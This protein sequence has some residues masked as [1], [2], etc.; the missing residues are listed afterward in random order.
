MG[1]EL[2]RCGK[3]GGSKLSEA[4]RRQ[5][6]IHFEILHAYGYRTL[7]YFRDSEW[8][9]LPTKYLPQGVLSMDALSTAT[10]SKLAKN[11]IPIWQIENPFYNVFIQNLIKKQYSFYKL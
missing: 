9:G 8:V 11:N 4:A 1:R 5:G 2:D 10:F 7:D 3:C 6:V